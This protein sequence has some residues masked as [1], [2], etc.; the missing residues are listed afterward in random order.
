MQLVLATA[1]AASVMA[2]AGC[3]PGQMFGGNCPE[4][5]YDVILHVT[6]ESSRDIDDVGICDEIACS[7]DKEIPAA[8][9][10]N[11]I[12][13]YGETDGTWAFS[14]INWM[15]ESAGFVAFVDGE[16]FELGDYDLVYEEELIAGPYCG[17]IP[18]VEP[19]VVQL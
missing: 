13:E 7:T 8:S 19:L 6:V 14:I 3:A 18:A 5:D 10:V 17:S 1:G 12:Y 11:G 2:L 16:E 4:V 9:G 15:P